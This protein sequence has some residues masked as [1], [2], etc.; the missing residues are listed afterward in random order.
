MPI[1]IEDGYST[2][3]TEEEE[4]DGDDNNGEKVKISEQ[5]LRIEIGEEKMKE[6]QKRRTPERSLLEIEKENDHQNQTEEIGGDL[7]V[8]LN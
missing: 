5:L 8:P 6:I 3:T 4:S 1:I 2:T 7:I